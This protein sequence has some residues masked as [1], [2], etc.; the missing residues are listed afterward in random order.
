MVLI[1]KILSKKKLYIMP[2]SCFWKGV[3]KWVRD[4]ERIKIFMDRIVK[5]AEEV[6]K[7]RTRKKG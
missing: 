3:K 1:V 6:E 2:D 5:I 7:K 4:R